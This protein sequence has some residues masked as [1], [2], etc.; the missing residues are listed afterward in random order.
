M[1]RLC[2]LAVDTWRW[3]R[4]NIHGQT[5]LDLSY[6]VAVLG[7]HFRPHLAPL[8][9]FSPAGINAC[10][11]RVCPFLETPNSLPLEV[12]SSLPGLFSLCLTHVG[13][14]LGLRVAKGHLFTQQWEW[15]VFATEPSYCDGFCW[16]P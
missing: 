14:V 7:L 10:A 16:W 4:T 9:T 11:R 13:L 2:Q 3:K 12:L 1:N 15:V 6:R 8:A 5:P